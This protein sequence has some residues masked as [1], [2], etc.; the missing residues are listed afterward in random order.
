MENPSATKRFSKISAVIDIEKL[1]RE[2]MKFFYI[3]L[4]IGVFIHLLAGHFITYNS[5]GLAETEKSVVQHIKVDLITL[6]PRANNLDDSIER[7]FTS[8][9]YL[10]ELLRHGVPGKKFIYKPLDTSVDAPPY[11]EFTDIEEAIEY[12]LKLQADILDSLIYDF[13]PLHNFVESFNKYRELT[14]SREPENR[15]SLR[16]ELITLE[17]IDD[18][19]IYKAIV[20]Q[21]PND[22]QN[23][24][25]LIHIPMILKSIGMQS[26]YGLVNTINRYTLLNATV[27]Y[28]ISLESEHLHDFPFIYLTSNS[29]FRINEKEKD[30]F[31]KYL[32]GGGFAFLDNYEPYYDFYPG[33][34]AL[35][36]M[37]TD[38]FGENFDFHPI[39]TNHP[40]FSCFFNMDGSAPEGAENWTSYRTPGVVQW[41]FLFHD[42]KTF[43]ML[44]SLNDKVSKVKNS[45]WGVWIDG[46]LAAI[47]SDKGYGRIWKDGSIV[48]SSRYYYAGSE[49]KYD[50]NLQLKVGINSL[51]YSLIREGSY[52]V[53]EVD[54]SEKGN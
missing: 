14:I 41:G 54:Y 43:R 51:V 9:T 37:L 52:S 48:G 44:K 30:N 3:G 11:M 16:D 34:A 47:Y 13:K 15:F 19:G 26:L 18:L 39:P 20:V 50:F 23:L 25:G 29:I 28:Y 49:E 45:L 24:K 5:I 8:R 17:D 22:K 31:A 2:S 27:D 21:D 10:E 33:E 42:K 1:E 46:R 32:K 6:P 35:Y 4:V 40:V 53:K 12:A 36:L 38:T 7:E